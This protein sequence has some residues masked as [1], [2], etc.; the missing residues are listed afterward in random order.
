MDL[1]RLQAFGTLQ[2]YK[3][4]HI[5]FKEGDQDTN[6]Y[7]ILKGAV[8]IRGMAEDRS[9]SEVLEAGKFFGDL[10]AILDIPKQNTCIIE[11]DDTA[12]MSIPRAKFED[13]I[14]EDDGFALR[15]MRLLAERRLKALQERDALMLRLSRYETPPPKAPV[16]MYAPVTPEKKKQG[17]ETAENKISDKPAAKAAARGPEG[18]TSP[19]ASAQN[20]PTGM[21]TLIKLNIAPAGH[22][23]YPSRQW[24]EAGTA[25]TPKS[26][27]C[28]LCE[29]KFSATYLSRTRMGIAKTEPDMRKRYRIVE[30]MYFEMYTCP[31][32]GYANF[33]EDF[34]KIGRGLKE[35]VRKALMAVTALPG[36]METDIFNINYI[37]LKFYL[38]LLC[39]RGTREGV[40]VIP[41]IWLR[42]CWLYED[43]EDEEMITFAAG[44]AYNA[45]HETFY[46]TKS[47]TGEAENDVLLLLGELALKLGK[48]QEAR[49]HF[50]DVLL[51]GM[52]TSVQR[53]KAESR[54][55][56]IRSKEGASEKDE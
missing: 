34:E 6:M 56:D 55:Y 50:M 14:K 9:E 24:P 32:C 31:H 54:I 33:S 13:F 15:I 49:K 48:E 26:M 23:T 43:A 17:R 25:L 4:G 10:S 45:Y 29:K 38:M 37:F 20:L 41:K 11:E 51:G 46:K 2:N 27:V 7:I 36:D 39:Y 35:D 8:S 47:Y 5:L 16:D 3:R 21:D 30:P 22:K 40:V 12:L 52:P 1:K 42:L 53:S 18:K 44:Q 28:P 19:A